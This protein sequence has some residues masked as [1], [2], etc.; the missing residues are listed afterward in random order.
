MTAAMRLETHMVDTLS[1]GYDVGRSSTVNGTS[2]CRY[3]VA[4]G[5]L[6][7]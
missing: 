4:Y 7:L 5:S 1:L 6:Y 3:L 2:D